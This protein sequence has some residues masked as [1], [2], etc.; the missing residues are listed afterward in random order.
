MGFSL[1]FVIS[2]ENHYHEFICAICAQLAE[3]ASLTPC[4]HVF[5]SGCIER[6]RQVQR[7]ETGT[8]PTCPKCMHTLPDGS[9]VDLASGSPLA[10]RIFG[11]VRCRCPIANCPWVGDF[12]GL[13]AHLTNS[14]EHTGALDGNAP[15]PEPAASQATATRALSAG[16]RAVYTHASGQRETVLI[17]KV[18][19]VGEGGGYTIKLMGE[20]GHERSTVAERLEPL[21]QTPQVPLRS[22]AT[23]VENNEATSGFEDAASVDAPASG[24]ASLFLATKPSVV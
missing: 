10:A 6:W 13:Q 17:L 2:D 12:D 9:V 4:N 19:S 15:T 20:G 3:P 21:P 22:T 11:R 5:C 7:T 1:D 14:A 24:R 8:E 18:H 16:D 23:F